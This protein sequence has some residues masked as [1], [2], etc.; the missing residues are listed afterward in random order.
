M[1]LET[2]VFRTRRGWFYR[3]PKSDLQD[4]DIA[5]EWI[6]KIAETAGVEIKILNQPSEL[7]GETARLTEAVKREKT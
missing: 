5:V 6:K 3:V 2:V 4:K 1:S 7:P